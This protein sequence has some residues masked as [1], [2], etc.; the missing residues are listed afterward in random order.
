M[1]W[2]GPRLSCR[3]GCVCRGEGDRREALLE[4]G[5]VRAGFLG[6]GPVVHRTSFWRSGCLLPETGGRRESQVDIP[7]IPRTACGLRRGGLLPAAPWFPRRGLLSSVAAQATSTRVLRGPLGTWP[8]CPPHPGSGLARL[9]LRTL[10]GLTSAFSPAGPSPSL[11]VLRGQA[12]HSPAVLRV[13]R[14]REH[15]RGLVHSWGRRG[16]TGPWW[17]PWG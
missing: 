12:G 17:G 10:G 3:G 9:D 1:A 6:E 4:R 7:G 14:G 5:W 16:G 11:W 8:P 2:G 13:G 15:P